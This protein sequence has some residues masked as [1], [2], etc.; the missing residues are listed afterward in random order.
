MTLKSYPAKLK[1]PRVQGF[2]MKPKIRNDSIAT[3]EGHE[4]LRTFVEGDAYVF[5]ATFRFSNAAEIDQF[6]NFLKYDINYGRDWFKADWMTGLGFAAGTQAFV[7]TRSAEKQAGY[8]RE[9]TVDMLMQ[10]VADA[11][12]PDVDWPT[13]T[14]DPGFQ[15]HRFA[16]VSPSSEIV[17]VTST[18]VFD[19]KAGEAARGQW[20]TGWV[21]DLYD[22]GDGSVVSANKAILSVVGDKITLSSPFSVLPVANEH[23]IRFSEYD[24]VV[25][26]Q[27]K[28]GFVSD[29]DNDF[30]SDSGKAYRIMYG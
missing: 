20:Q 21:V 7:F 14:T 17:A 13:N 30:P 15:D 1:Q 25:A 24:N 26:A 2:T 18:S 3:E 6:N 28:L 11:P 4:R 23:G 5:R 22:L 19:L 10:P 27:K 12:N 9:Y 29:D 8:A 16:L